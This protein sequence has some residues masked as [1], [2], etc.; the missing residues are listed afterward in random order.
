VEVRVRHD[1]QDLGV[2]FTTLTGALLAVLAVVP[3]L[4][5]AVTKVPG[6]AAADDRP[7]RP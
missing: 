2:V 5:H 1:G 4:R 6:A 7:S 3:R